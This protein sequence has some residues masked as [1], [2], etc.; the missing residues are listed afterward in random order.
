MNKLIYLA[1][2]YTYNPDESFDI[3]NEVAAILM[4]D[5][6]IVFSPVSHSHKIADYLPEKMRFSQTFWMNQDLPILN[7]CD[8]LYLVKIGKNGN[9]LINESKGCQS[10]IKCAIENNIPIKYFQYDN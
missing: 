2:P 7:K 3:A 10:E 6:D 8:E 1:I 5:G 4:T 9:K